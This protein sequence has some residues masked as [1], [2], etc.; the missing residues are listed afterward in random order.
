MRIAVSAC[1]AAVALVAG[2]VANIKNNELKY[3][4]YAGAPITS[5]Y[6]PSLDGWTAVDDKLLVVRTELNK[7]YLLKL[8]GFCPNLKFANAIG[9]TST[10]SNVDKFEKV[11]V[12]QDKCMINEIRPI[13]SAH[14]KADRKALQKKKTEDSKQILT[15]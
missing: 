1:L 15:Q 2:C 11:I 3:Q 13:D 4:D 12:G 14:M 9:V 7:E 6:M 5:F 8:S 10:A